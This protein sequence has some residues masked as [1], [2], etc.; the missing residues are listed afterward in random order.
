MV[1][2]ERVTEDICTHEEAQK[3][4]DGYKVHP[5]GWGREAEGLCRIVTEKEAS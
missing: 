5:S 1:E 4:Y 2:R 3:V